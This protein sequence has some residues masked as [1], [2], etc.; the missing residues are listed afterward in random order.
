LAVPFF[1]VPL[2]QPL[3]LRFALLALQGL[4]NFLPEEEVFSKAKSLP[5]LLHWVV[6]LQ[7]AEVFL[8][9]VVAFLV[10]FLPAFLRVAGFLGFTGI[11]RRLSEEEY[12]VK[13]KKWAYCLVR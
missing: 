2:R 6:I 8:P 1:L 7:S 10:G 4:F 5:A 13:V 11:I 12:A 9:E 3:A